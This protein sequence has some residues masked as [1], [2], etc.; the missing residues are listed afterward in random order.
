MVTAS[1]QT[2]QGYGATCFHRLVTEDEEMP[3]IGTNEEWRT[4]MIRAR[5]DAGL[6]QEALG[7]RV[8]LSQPMIWKIETGA[9]P[10][11]TYILR[12]CRALS[13][14]APEH[15]ATEWQQD[16]SRLGHV[17]RTQSPDQSEAAINMV[18]A[19]VKALAKSEATE[20]MPQDPEP[21]RK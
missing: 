12:I 19:M 9:S 3:E 18:R 2:T 1:L 5:K 14:P 15:F 8:G 10:S 11:S 7:E 13:I 17:L 20:S 16:W 21:K 6:S 4:I